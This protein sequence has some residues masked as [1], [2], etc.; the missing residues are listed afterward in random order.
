M[1]RGEVVFLN[2]KN[3]TKYTSEKNIYG[4]VQLTL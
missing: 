3:Y 2:F 1:L 4:H